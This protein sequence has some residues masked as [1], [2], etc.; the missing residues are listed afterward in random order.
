MELIAACWEGN[1][2]VGKGMNQ[3]GRNQ[4]GRTEGKGN[5]RGSSSACLAMPCAW[6]FQHIPSAS[7]TLFSR[8]PAVRCAQAHVGVGEEPQPCPC[9]PD[10]PACPGENCLGW[11]SPKDQ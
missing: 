7:Q 6:W 2:C 1:G 9:S 4:W 8:F 5:K 10:V 11:F 3:G